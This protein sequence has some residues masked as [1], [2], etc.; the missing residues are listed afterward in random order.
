MWEP[1]TS[2]RLGGIRAE[3]PASWTR[4]LLS[5]GAVVRWVGLAAGGI[6]GLIAPPHAPAVLA[7]LILT[8][9]AYNAWLML[10]VRRAG[11]EALPRIAGTV[12]LL[13]EI[14]C[15]VF[16][17]LFANLPGGAQSS[18]YVP[19]VIEAVAY[20]GV[21]GAVKSVAV[22]IPGTVLLQV[23]WATFD[24]LPFSWI[25]IVVW[26]LIILVIATALA[27]LERSMIAVTPVPG[28]KEDFIRNKGE[29]LAAVSQALR[30]S[31]REL[32]VLRLIADGYSNGMIASRLHISETTVKSYVETLRTRLG[33]KNRAEA[34][35]AASRLSLL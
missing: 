1:L 16:I 21:A 25:V 22:F 10:A 20:E 2:F 29:P 28:S 34:V 32:E 6:M 23:V 14:G 30:L 9:A 27:A 19:I 7:A 4:S 35:A 24:H 26:S 31:P 15:L 11:D 13:D 5:I 17:A 8:V 18:L 12:T 33:A 3:R